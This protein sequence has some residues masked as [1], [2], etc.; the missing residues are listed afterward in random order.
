MRKKG[1]KDFS[2]LEKDIQDMY[3]WRS[4]LLENET[5]ESIKTICYHHEY[6]YGTAFI[7]KNDKCC[8]VLLKKHKKER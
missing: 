7:R 1:L 2:T 5:N 3:L 6:V 4:C 8:N